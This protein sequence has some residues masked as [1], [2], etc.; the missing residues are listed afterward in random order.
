MCLAQSYPRG[1]DRLRRGSDRLRK[2][3]CVGRLW[4]SKLDVDDK[5]TP[6]TERVHE[7]NGLYRP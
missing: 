1:S 5:V 4:T 7:D 6:A 3:S 2:G